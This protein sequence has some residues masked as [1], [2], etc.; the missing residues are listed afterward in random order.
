[1]QVPYADIEKVLK[2]LQSHSTFTPALLH[3]PDACGELPFLVALNEGNIQMADWCDKAAAKNTIAA[4]SEK[5]GELKPFPKLLGL[6][7]LEPSICL[8]RLLSMDTN[9]VTNLCMMCS[10][11]SLNGNADSVGY[12]GH[13]LTE[14]DFS[15]LLQPN[16]SFG[17]YLQH[18]RDFSLIQ[19]YFK[20]ACFLH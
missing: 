6:A 17:K 3:A 8:Q 4:V 12:A 13:F 15:V 7:E 9:Q 14:N 20:Q 10:S 19:L 16:S 2:S 11:P 1:M 5:F 18:S